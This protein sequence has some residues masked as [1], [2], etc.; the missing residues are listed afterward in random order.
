MPI[1]HRV[2]VLLDPEADEPQRAWVAGVRD[3]VAPALETW[4]ASLLPAADTVGFAVRPVG[5]DGTLGAAQPLTLA[6]LGLSALDALWLVGD[7]PASVPAPLRTLAASRIETKLQVRIDPAD[8]AGAKLALREFSVLAVELRRAVDSLRVADARDLRPAHTPGEADTDDST[9]LAAVEGLIVKFGGLVDDLDG[10]VQAQDEKGVASIAEWM[11]RVGLSV[12]AAP[13]D[14]ASAGALHTLAVHRLAAVGHA[15][16]G[17]TER[18]PRLER[19]LAALLGGRVP[20]LGTFPIVAAEGGDVVDLTAGLAGAEEVD[21]WL[22]A[23]GR[24][25]PDLARLTAAGM[26]SELLTPDGGLRASA[27]QTPLLPGDEW[28]ATASP[29]PDTAGR[30][31]LVAIH[32]PAGPPA[33]GTSACGLVVD[34]WS[35]R[36]P[37]NEQVTGMAFQ[38]DAPSNQAPQAWLLAVTP[39]GEQWSLQLVLDTLLETLEWATLRSVGPEDLL[40][41]GR[42]IPTVFV[43][44]DIVSWPPEEDYMATGWDRLESMARTVDL[45][46]GLE[47]RVA[48]PMW[49]L[50]RQWQVGE[51]RGD[52]AAQP[53]AVRM[54]GRSVPLATFRPPGGR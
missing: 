25:R 19:Q 23:V 38:F 18:R 27:G 13:A 53:A 50:A 31:S 8:R 9:A 11:A 49:K 29:A 47:A 17:V 42:A 7:D 3:A 37:R 6:K 52:D 54:Q 24:A 21:D 40:D 34:R 30:T 2:V 5:T 32:G 12:G 26:L 44:G 45:D 33:P 43:P 51:F 46:G 28:A 20:I 4:I 15:A 36:I 1:E 14:L 10:A 41:Y 48:D 22:D 39:D 35:E 16:A